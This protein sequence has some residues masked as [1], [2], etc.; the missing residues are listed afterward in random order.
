MF[1]VR[2]ESIPALLCLLYLHITKTSSNNCSKLALHSHITYC[3][4]ILHQLF[5]TNILN[6]RNENTM[7]QNQE[8]MSKSMST[9]LQKIAAKLKNQ[10]LFNQSSN[11]PRCIMHHVQ[12]RNFASCLSATRNFGCWLLIYDQ[13]LT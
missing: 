8:R 1:Y 4:R 2:Y 11:S 3:I 5:V 6:F 7:V 9:Y 13:K 12:K 10:P